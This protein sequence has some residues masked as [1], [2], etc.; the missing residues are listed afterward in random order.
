LQ[1]S[2][3]TAVAGIRVA[4]D[5][6]AFCM[7]TVDVGSTKARPVIVNPAQKMAVL[8]QSWLFQPLPV[9]EREWLAPRCTLVRY[10]RGARIVRRGV[11]GQALYVIAQGQVKG[12][13]TSPV[14]DGEF[15]IALLWPGDSF[16]ECSVLEC[17]G[18]VGNAVAMTDVQLLAVPRADMLAL[19]ERC[20]ALRL[21]LLG[22]IIDKFRTALDLNLS[23]RF[24]DIPERLYQ[25]MLYLARFDSRR[26]E[27]G[28]HIHHGLSQQ[29]LADSIG[30]SR[31]ALNKVIGDWKREGL[32][33][34]SRGY[35]LV[36]DPDGF[37]A[38]MPE[39]LR[40]NPYFGAPM[41]TGYVP[42]PAFTQSGLDEGRAAPAPM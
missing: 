20:P 30:V 7:S 15:V 18:A 11:A 12:T 13:L 39:S 19:L 5:R 33:E 14:G 6:H 2:R 1:G 32:V 17:P 21:R 41:S 16:G 3:R 9:V 37:S 28:L 4:E 29:E 26:D 25:R 38:R 42:W 24:L 8:Q 35:I 27:E 34:W 22:A 40:Q 10:R 23:L 31:E 36:R